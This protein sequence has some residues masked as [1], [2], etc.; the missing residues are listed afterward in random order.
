MKVMC[1]GH[2][3]LK[4][5]GYD[6]PNPTEQW[7]RGT[8]HQTLASLL[9]RH[10]KLHGLTGMALGTDLLFA[11]ECKRLGIPYTAAVPFAGQEKR[12]PEASQ[13]RYRMLLK[14]AEE[15]VVVDEIPKYHS[16][17]FGGKMVLRNK[18]LVD[19]SKLTIAVWDGSGKGGTANAVQ[20]A[21]KKRRKVLVFDP[22]ARTAHTIK[23]AP[24]KS[25]NQTDVFD[26]FGEGS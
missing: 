1:T 14:A 25:R 12:W 16:D 17:H 9:E 19:H 11:E 15:V 2:R 10:P 13:N 5:G 7:V 8:L 3:P 24:K 18:W 6:T 22:R 26:L 21:Q 4:I 20:M 23:P